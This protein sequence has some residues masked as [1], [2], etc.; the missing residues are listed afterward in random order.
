MSD[1]RLKWRCLLFLSI[2]TCFDLKTKNERS[3]FFFQLQTQLSKFNTRDINANNELFVS[4]KANNNLQNVLQKDFSF[5]KFEIVA[6]RTQ[7]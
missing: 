7:L 3:N 6:P 5:P 2:L 1:A 4:C